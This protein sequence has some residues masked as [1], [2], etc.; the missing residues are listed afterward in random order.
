MDCDEA[1]AMAW[2]THMAPVK[3]PLLGVD[4]HMD[5]LI[6]AAAAVAAGKDV[7]R[8]ARSLPPAVHIHY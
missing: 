3:H 7:W 2:Y 4:G 8:H 1:T 5:P 6:I